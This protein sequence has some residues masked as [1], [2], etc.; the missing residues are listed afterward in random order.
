M[1][2]PTDNKA[3]AKM[4]DSPNFLRIEVFIRQTRAMGRPKMAKSEKS[5]KVG[6][7][8]QEGVAIEATAREGRVKDLG[9]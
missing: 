3:V 7:G 1:R 8:K 4:A 5:V 9:P 6:T 2:R